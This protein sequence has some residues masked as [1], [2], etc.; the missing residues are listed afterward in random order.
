MKTLIFPDG[1][2]MTGFRWSMF[3]YWYR[4][5]PDTGIN[6]EQINSLKFTKKAL[7]EAG[8]AIRDTIATVPDKASCGN[9]GAVHDVDDLNPI[10]DLF[11]RVAPGEE[12]PAGECPEEDCCGALCHLI[13][14]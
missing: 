8:I 1:Q 9:C 5:F 14:E 6:G 4:T 10:S 11:Q 12:M 13:S 2:K 3:G 7:A